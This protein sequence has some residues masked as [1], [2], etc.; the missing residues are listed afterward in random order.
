MPLEKDVSHNKEL[1]K[2]PTQPTNVGVL[3]G[4]FVRSSRFGCGGVLGFFLPSTP[5]SDEQARKTSPLCSHPL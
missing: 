2:T 3:A 5:H 4:F 1:K